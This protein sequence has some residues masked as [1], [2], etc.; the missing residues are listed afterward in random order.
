MKWETREA[1]GRYAT[2]GLDAQHNGAPAVPLMRPDSSSRTEANEVFQRGGGPSR[3]SCGYNPRGFIRA[4][5]SQLPQGLKTGLR[6]A[7]GQER[8]NEF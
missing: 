7:F 6:C 1:P 8:T 5:L 3:Y 4:T 2:Q